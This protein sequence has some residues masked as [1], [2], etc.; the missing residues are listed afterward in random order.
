[1]AEINREILLPY[2]EAYIPY[3]EKQEKRDGD[4]L[5]SNAKEDYKRRVA[6]RIKDIL[7]AENWTESEIES[8]VIRDR[9]FKAVQVHVN[10]VGRFQIS[11]FNDLVNKDLNQAERVFYDFYHN[12]KEQE[13]FDQICGIFGRT[14][15]IV[16]YLYFINNP[17][18]Y[19]PIKPQYFDRIFKRLQIDLK[20]EGRCSWDNYQEFL[21]IVSAVR[22]YMRE[23]YQEP[24]IDLL[25]AH[26]FLWTTDQGVLDGVDAKEQEP[27]E[28]IIENEGEE[29][30]TIVYHKEYGVGII[31]KYSDENV[32][33]RFGERTYIFQYPEA[34]DRGYLKNGKRGYEQK[35]DCNHR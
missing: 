26:S 34:F 6:A 5:L 13:C 15:N 19:L 2:M 12:H 10:L 4:R 8:G 31:V 33:V 22:D 27:V 28:D 23:Y 24:D 21:D 16:A 30:E 1:M 29:D 3:L 14:Y 17:E 25:D 32:Y 9:V 7:N 18:K 35:K 11:S 20:T